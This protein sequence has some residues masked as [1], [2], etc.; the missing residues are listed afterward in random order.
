MASV[1]G[2]SSKG[3]AS[4]I[5]QSTGF[6]FLTEGLGL[7]QSSGSSYIESILSI[8]FFHNIAMRIL[9][10]I[11][12]SIVERSATY[13]ELEDKVGK[14]SDRNRVLSN[15]NV[16]VNSDNRKLIDRC[17][18]IDGQRELQ[19][20]EAV[21]KREEAVRKREEEEEEEEA[22]NYLRLHKKI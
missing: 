18:R 10:R 12:N 14:L 20:E 21:R 22:I 19:E 9:N 13:K 3:S 8:T 6:S 11:I 7:T 17:R 16:N 5:S 4:G 15:Y 2:V 1:Y